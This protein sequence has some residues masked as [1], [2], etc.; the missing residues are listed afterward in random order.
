MH[1]TLQ[2]RSK[3][4]S[5]GQ[6]GT[7]RRFENSCTCTCILAKIGTYESPRGRWGAPV[8]TGKV[9]LGDPPRSAPERRG[10][11]WL[12]VRWDKVVAWVGEGS[13]CW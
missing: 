5:Q 1:A 11:G 7:L 3:S 13:R 8:V 10:S 12:D 9:C 2:W 4:S 6:K